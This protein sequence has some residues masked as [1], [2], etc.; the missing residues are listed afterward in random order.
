M[1]ERARFFFH[2]ALAHFRGFFALVQID[3]VA[4][5]TARMR[6]LNETE[7]IAARRVAFLRE[8]FDDIAIHDFVAQ[9][10]HLAVHFCA[11]ALV[12]DF[13]VD[14]VGEIDG[15]GAARKFDDAAFRS[16]RIDFCSGE[17]DFQR[18]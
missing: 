16:E 5:F 11:D 14:G 7:P 4:D 18:A 17:V 8:N 1:P 12:A 9:R 2:Q 6:R 10:D 3:P 15:R 13:G